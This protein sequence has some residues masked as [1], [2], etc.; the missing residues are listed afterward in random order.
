MNCLDFRREALIQPLRLGDAA[1]RHADECPGC[2]AFLER[3]RELEAQLFDALA[4]PA[5]DGL[6][7]RVLVA[8][9]IRRRARAWPWA[10]AATLVIAAGVAMLALPALQGGALAAEAI[11]HVVDEPQ[12][13]AGK[14]RDTAILPAAL[15]AQGVRLAGALGEVTYA[16]LCP[17]GGSHARHLVVATARGPVTLL[18]MPADGSGHARAMREAGGFTAIAVPAARGSIAIVAASRDDALAVERMLV[19]T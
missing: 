2:R 15:A 18:L 8:Q 6:A 19:P 9:G 3:Q 12:S 7:D 11:A 16:Q 14:A 1:R 5:P 13:F 10:L 4:V 17:F